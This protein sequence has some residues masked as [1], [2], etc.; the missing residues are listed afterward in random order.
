M[1]K[2]QI[3]IFTL[4]VLLS[5]FSAFASN[6]SL[7]M[8]FKGKDPVSL[9]RFFQTVLPKGEI[10]F[11]IKN[12]SALEITVSAI[13]GNLIPLGDSHWK[14]EAPAKPGNYELII[15][16]SKGI[17]K[18][19]INIFV[20]VPSSEMKGEY[21]N[22]YR[23]GNYPEEKYKGNSNYKKPDGFIE[24][25]E[26]NSDLF[27]SPHFQLKQFLSK[28]VSAWPK[29]ILLEPKLILKLEHLISGLNK[30]GLKAST[31]FIMSG[32][33]T[34]YY[35][36]SIGNVKYSR[37]IY[38]DAA[39]VYVDENLD[40]VIDDLDH[41]GRGGMGD[42]LIIHEIINSFDANPE[43]EHFVGGMGKYK[44]NSAHTYFIHID[45][46]GYKARW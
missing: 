8:V 12:N 17:T 5:N 1:R 34:P 38:G 44:K 2:L 10:E 25:T 13:H 41:D 42:A 35:N 27:L 39:D 32:Y 22:G 46:R 28:Q 9:E 6:D 20:L 4:F 24:V 23:I 26:D 11:T 31:L 29:Y 30:R 36:K 3:T 14:Y 33:R 18:M 15:H 40:G 43:N 16:D 37:H 45:T 19:T 7:M 21:L